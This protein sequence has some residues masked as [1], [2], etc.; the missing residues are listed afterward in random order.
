ME[1]QSNMNRF[2]IVQR[3]HQYGTIMMMNKINYSEADNFKRSFKKLSKKFRTLP[4]DLEV[5][6]K[7]AIEL[8]HLHDID[9][10]SIILIPGYD[11]KK[12]QI[13][14]L[15]KFACRA[16]KGKGVMSGIRVIYAHDRDSQMVT[17]I[18]IYFKSNQA[19][20]DKSKIEDFL[21]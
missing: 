19:N 7:N 16:L 11:H 10:Q 12:F 9:N 17:F 6:K 8:L 21:K 15:R 18:E 1:N 3:T 14:K 5:A 20:E 2:S 4:D 13:Y